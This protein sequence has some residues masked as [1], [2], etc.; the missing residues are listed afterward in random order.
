MEPSPVIRLPDPCLVVLAGAAGAG[1]STFAAAHFAPGEV[2]SSD[3]Y[4]GRI[5][6]DPTDQRATGAA[7]AALHRELRRRLADRRLTVVD[8]TSVQRGARSALLRDAAMA[9]IPAIAIVLDLPPDIVLARNAQRPGARA[10]P[11]DVV[12]RQHEELRRAL[13]G[14]GL[15]REGFALVMRLRDPAVVDAVRIE[16]GPAPATPPETPPVRPPHS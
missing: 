10:V 14:G 3:A 6:G 12:R 5:A 11:E 13:Q 7:F 4:R 16:R 15:E 1:K 9:W 8:A 2:L